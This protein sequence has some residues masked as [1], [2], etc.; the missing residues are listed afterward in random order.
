MVSWTTVIGW[1]RGLGGLGELRGLSGFGGLGGLGDLGGLGGLGGFRDPYAVGAVVVHLQDRELPAV[2]GLEGVP[3]RRDAP[4][5]RG[6]EARDGFVRAL[7][8]GQADAGELVQPYAAVRLPGA[9]AEGHQARRLVGVVFVA[10]VADDLLDDVLQGGD[11]RGAPVLVDDDGHGVRSAQPVQQPVHRE[12]VGHQE[13]GRGQVGDGGGGAA[14]GVQGEDVADVHGADHL[15]QGVAVDGE[16]GPPGGQGEVGRVGGGGVGLQRLDVHARGHHVLGGQLAQVER[17]DEQLGRVL[18]QRALGGRVAGQ[19]HQLVRR[20]GG[21]QLLG[22]LQ[23]HAA[24]QAVGRVVEVVDQRGEGGGEGALRGGD[25]LGHVQGA[26]DGPVLGHQLPGDHQHHRG[27]GHAQHHGGRRRRAFGQADRGER[28]FEQG[29]QRG[30][31]EHADHQGGDGDAQ[32]GPGELERQSAH[33]RERADGPALTGF[34]GALQGAA[35]DGGE[36][37]LGGHEERAG[38]GEGQG[39]EKQQDLGHRATPVCPITGAPP[40]G[41][42]GVARV[43]LGG[44]P[45]AGPVLLTS[46]GSAGRAL[47]GQVCPQP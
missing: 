44:S 41:G 6:Q 11:A 12:A 33:R 5:G 19:R 24:H 7:G 1:P 22:G 32:L 21:G 46:L 42:R 15:V 18:L 45:I 38:E 23:A 9:G 37:E 14:G 8:G 27:D 47:V 25:R 2:V 35:F 13:R 40:K 16:A 39:E 17:T 43:V 30:L 4:Q 31:G 20:T 34:G 10:D 3:G 28:G 36:G 26:G 29:G